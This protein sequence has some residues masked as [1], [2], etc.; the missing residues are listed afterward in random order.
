MKSGKDSQYKESMFMM[1]KGKTSKN[2][3]DIKSL[4]TYM[5]CN[6]AARRLKCWKRLNGERDAKGLYMTQCIRCNHI[7]KSSEQY[8]P[9]MARLTSGWNMMYNIRH[10]RIQG[11]FGRYTVP[12]INVYGYSSPHPGWMRL[13]SVPPRH[14]WHKGNIS[15]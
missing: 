14:G 9:R 7:R 3:Y 2:D 13:V 11:M 15:D 12:D 10:F 8:D 5:W 1:N 4:P 6:L